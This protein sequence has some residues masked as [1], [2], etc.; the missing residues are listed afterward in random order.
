MIIRDNKAFFVNSLKQPEDMSL[1]QMMITE[2]TMG[3]DILNGSNN[4]K[5][6]KKEKKTSW[7]WKYNSSARNVVRMWW[8]SKFVT[9]LL[10]RLA[11]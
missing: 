7:E 2:K 9:H 1:Q 4:S 8:L 3:I 6:L 10:G 5:K 11:T